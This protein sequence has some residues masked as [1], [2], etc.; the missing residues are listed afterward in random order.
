VDRLN[1]TTIKILGLELK[2][3]RFIRS[4]SFIQGTTVH[5]MRTGLVFCICL[6]FKGSSA[7]GFN[8]IDVLLFLLFNPLQELGNVDLQ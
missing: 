5:F 3:V 7:P 1:G 6:F 4:L 2:K 8:N